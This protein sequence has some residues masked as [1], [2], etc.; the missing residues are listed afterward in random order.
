MLKIKDLRV[1]YQ[2]VEAVKGV[3]MEVEEGSIVT[4]IG[5]N[6]AGKSTILRTISGLKTPTAGEIWFKDQRIDKKAPQHIV[7]AGISQC[8]EGRRVF[9]Y[10]SVLENLMMGAYTRKDKAGI[11]RDMENVYRHFPR[12]KERTKQAAGTLSGG[13]QQ[14]LA[15]GRALMAGPK[16]MLLDEP[17]IG[18]S[19]L[20]VQEIAKI[21]REIN[22]DG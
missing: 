8:P 2:K 10:M 11:K 6:G 18:L 22:A 21:I 14:M 13:E 3:S 1:H 5:A 17:S 16:L 15:M 20:L 7:K 12:L 9:P 4:F 19:P